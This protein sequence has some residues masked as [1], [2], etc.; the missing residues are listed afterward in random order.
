VDTLRVPRD[1]MAR[2]FESWRDG[3]ANTVA[4][5]AGMSH[6]EAHAGF[7]DIAD[8]IRSPQGYAVWQV[9]IVTGLK[10]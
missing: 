5:L 8:C 10:A 9:P 2:I 1:T 4:D 3:Y 7:T 6:E